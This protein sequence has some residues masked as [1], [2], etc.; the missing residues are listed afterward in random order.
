MQ[1]YI[2]NYII[3]GLSLE[4]YGIVYP[5]LNIWILLFVYCLF[6]KCLSYVLNTMYTVLYLQSTFLR[7]WN[8]IM[9]SALEWVA[10]CCQL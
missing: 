5:V 8:K 6:C 10:G 1:W 3:Y 9:C 2:G 7:N 4:C